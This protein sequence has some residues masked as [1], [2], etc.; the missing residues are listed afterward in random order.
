MAVCEICGKKRMVGNNV[1]HSN[2]RTKRTFGANIHTVK[3]LKP[4][5][6]KKAKV[7]TTCLKAGKV[8]KA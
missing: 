4:G 6:S 1:S 7:C 5:R 2:N 8:Q 3:M